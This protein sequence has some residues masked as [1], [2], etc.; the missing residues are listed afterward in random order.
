MAANTP[1]LGDKAQ[2]ETLQKLLDRVG[3]LEKQA[4]EQEVSD[5]KARD[6]VEKHAVNG[7]EA[8]QKAHEAVVGQL[9][10]RIAEL[11]N[12]VVSWESS[13]VLPEITVAGESG[14]TPQELDQK[15]RVIERKNELAAEAS[16][17]RS[18][19]LSI[20]PRCAGPIPT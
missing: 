18:K 11:E 2:A 10:T 5:R 8:A 19:E 15:I 20:T 12:K 16:E 4:L 7:T 6:S 13:K 1:D 14:P 17:S 3:Q 9:K